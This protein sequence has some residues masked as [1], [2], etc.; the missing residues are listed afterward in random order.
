MLGVKK[1]S[2]PYLNEC[3]KKVNSDI[4]RYRKIIEIIDNQSGR[5][6]SDLINFEHSFFNNMIILLDSF[7]VHRLRGIE[8]KDGNPLNEV[9]AIA[10]SIAGNQG[11]MMKDST[12]RLKPQH[13]L[14]KYD[15]GDEIKV[16]ES[17]F[18]L[19]SKAFFSEIER[20]YT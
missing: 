2:S 1:Y 12:I 4:S 10:N 7:F 13:S 5:N 8:G 11:I 16:S 19:I 9:R 3:R 18:A 15:L 6:S 17:Q 14:L 20:K